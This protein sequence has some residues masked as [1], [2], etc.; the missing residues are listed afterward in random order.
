LRAILALA[1]L[2]IPS[3]SSKTST[4][5]SNRFFSFS[6]AVVSGFS[7]LGFQQLNG[8]PVEAKLVKPIST[9]VLKEKSLL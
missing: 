8:F 1:D 2:K 5:V 6:C 4:Y 3:L 7:W 9:H